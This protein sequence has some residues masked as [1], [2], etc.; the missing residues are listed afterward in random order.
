MTAANANSAAS[1]RAFIKAAQIKARVRIAPG[2]GSI[3]VFPPTYEARFSAGEI[4][5]FTTEARDAGFT[6]VRGVPIDPEHEKELTGKQ[7][8]SFYP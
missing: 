5:A 3:Q 1:L 4:S 6:F 2:G 7:H 8:W